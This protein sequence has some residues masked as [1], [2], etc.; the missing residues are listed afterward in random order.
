M[1]VSKLKSNKLWKSIYYFVKYENWLPNHSELIW[2]NNG[3]RFL[4]LK[5]KNYWIKIFNIEM[6]LLFL[7]NSLN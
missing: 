6:L 5:M 2:H 4:K 1:N 3:I 7:Y